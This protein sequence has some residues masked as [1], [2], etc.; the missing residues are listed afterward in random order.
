LRYLDETTS[1]ARKILCLVQCIPESGMSSRR[2]M[3]ESVLTLSKRRKLFLQAIEYNE[4]I[5][6]SRDSDL[7]GPDETNDKAI[8]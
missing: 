2:R 6:K 5:G 1:A 7:G 8:Q 4:C 3:R